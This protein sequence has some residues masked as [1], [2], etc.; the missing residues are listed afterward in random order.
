[1]TEDETNTR[2][3]ELIAAFRD[4]LIA[5]LTPETMV[6]CARDVMDQARNGDTAAVALVLSALAP[7]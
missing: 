1:M 6:R 4:E 3:A 5:R 2:Q 7:R